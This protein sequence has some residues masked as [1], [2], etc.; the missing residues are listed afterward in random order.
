MF[1]LRGSFYS[2]RLLF[3]RSKIRMERREKEKEGGGGKEKRKVGRREGGRKKCT[4]CFN[5]VLLVAVI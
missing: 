2:I 5:Q 1:F 4:L 3:R